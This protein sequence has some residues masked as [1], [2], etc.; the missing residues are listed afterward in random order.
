MLNC[1]WNYCGFG[2]SRSKDECCCIWIVGYGFEI[3]D[4]DLKWNDY[5]DIDV[6][7]KWLIILRGDPEIDSLTSPFIPYS[8]DRDKVML[9]FDHGAAGVLFVSGPKFDQKD[10]LVDLEKR[11]EGQVW[12]NKYFGKA[13]SQGRRNEYQEINILSICFSHLLVF[14][15]AQDGPV[16]TTRPIAKP[17]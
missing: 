3:D 2:F 5:S 16:F 13:I 1:I 9:A 11:R 6:T 17:D 4:E 12:T 8:R 15:P 10:K 7:D 14:R